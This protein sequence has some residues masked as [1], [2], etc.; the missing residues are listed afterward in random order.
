MVEDLTVTVHFFAALDKRMES[1]VCVAN[2][3]LRVYEELWAPEF[4]WPAHP[5]S[6]REPADP[7]TDQL[8]TTPNLD[9]T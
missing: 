7:S 5:Y 8:R 4:I 6:I 3:F 2:L 9:G 1:T